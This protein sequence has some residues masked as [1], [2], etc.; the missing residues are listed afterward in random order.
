MQE[1]GRTAARSGSATISAL[2]EPDWRER[3]FESMPVPW[4]SAL[5]FSTLLVHRSGLNRSDLPRISVQLRFDNL[6]NEESVVREFPEGLYLGEALS[7]SYPEL[8]SPA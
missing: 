6:E 4:G 5:V 8:V 2:N 1:R 3:E 7:A